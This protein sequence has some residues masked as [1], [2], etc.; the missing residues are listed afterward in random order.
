MLRVLSKGESE[1]RRAFVM[2]KGNKNG[3]NLKCRKV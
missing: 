2:L 3:T 1:G